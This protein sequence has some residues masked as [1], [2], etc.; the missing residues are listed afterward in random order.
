M[1]DE[2]EAKNEATVGER[3]ECLLGAPVR[4]IV[5]IDPDNVG[6]QSAVSPFAGE[7]ADPSVAGA[8]VGLDELRVG[9]G[10]VMKPR[11]LGASTM[12]M[13]YNYLSFLRI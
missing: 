1:N 10:V 7:D 12:E 11:S 5:G 4:Y 6:S 13:N 2:P 9:E 8:A 3:G